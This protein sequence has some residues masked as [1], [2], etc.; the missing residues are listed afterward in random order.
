MDTIFALASAAG[1]AGVAVVR[2]SGPAAFPIAETITGATLP[3]RGMSLRVLRNQIGAI[4]DH[5]LVLSFSAP[6]SYTGEDIVEFQT[7]GSIAVID[8]LLACLS[9][10]PDARMA[11]PGE[12]TRRALEN[13][14]LDLA[15]VEGLADLIDAETEQ[16][17]IQ[18]QRVFSGEL[19]NLARSWR[20]KLIRAAALVE[21]TIDFADEDVPVD[22]S[23]EV[24]DI[25]ESVRSDLQRQI[26]GSGIAERIR[27]GFEVAI[28]GAP[29]VGKSTLL[30]ALAG[31]PAALT[32]EYAGTTRDV[33]EVRMDLRGLPVTLL[34]TAGL[35]ETEDKVE[36]MGVSLAKTRAEAADLRI[37]LAEPGE[38]FDIKAGPEDI[39]LRPKADTRKDRAGAVSGLTGEG[40]DELVARVQEILSARSSDV[41]LAIRARHRKAME[42][43]DA[44]LGIAAEVLFR[45]PDH[46]DILAAEIR[47]AVLALESLVG[48]IHTEDLLSEIFASFCLGK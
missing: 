44:S 33:I 11:E 43:A 9:D 21:V 20:E 25:L 32:S 37:F 27:S 24:S 23:P 10:F 45:G 40:L 8:S 12:F 14:R 26:S 19:G 31:R 17:R 13:G 1:K 36:K 7:H 46:Y 29:N 22:V 16:Q 6:E 15:Q 3:P 39:I 38:S 47:H 5:A 18:A 35:R 41:G 42:T 30:N 2:L 28:V 48:R 4:L 34:D